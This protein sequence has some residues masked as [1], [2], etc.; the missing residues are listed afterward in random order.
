MLGRIYAALA[1]TSLV[2]AG[3][4]RPQALHPSSKW[5]LDYA[6]TQ[7]A[8]MR[9][10]GN[11]D[12]PI[13]FGIFPSPAGDFYE[14]KLAQKN[15]GSR[16]PREFEGSIDFGSGP[17]KGWLLQYGGA[18]KM[19]IDE[20]HIRS[21]E[22]TAARAA[23]SIRFRIK[24]R[25]D[26]SLELDSMPALMDELQRCTADLRK[27]WNLDGEKNGQIAVSSKGDVRAVFNSGDYPSEAVNRGQ[28]GTA[29]YLLLVD[30]KG[31]VADCHIVKAS[32]IPLLDAMG[33][34]VIRER[35]KLKPAR[36]FS[37][38]PVRSSYVTPPISWRLE[39]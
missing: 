28:D 1:L 5:D 11:T 35:T 9:D 34:A 39:D 30:Q 24:G 38:K 37:G 19:M 16:V 10:Y 23:Q 6:E 32:G 29:Q 36:D 4:A 3:D 25:P 20:F 14:I 13:G 27:Y 2:A 31:S 22:M 7:C 8:A 33:C 17:S 26:V 21:S 12:N 15:T 18:G